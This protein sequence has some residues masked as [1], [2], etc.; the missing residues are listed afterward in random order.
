MNLNLRGQLTIVRNILLY[1]FLSSY[2]AVA[3]G[4]ISALYLTAG[5]QARM[6]RVQGNTVSSLPEV[7]TGEYALA[8]RSTVRTLN[9]SGGGA[10]GNEYTLAGAPL[11]ATYANNFGSQMI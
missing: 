2:S 9:V 7:H 8:V 1:A 4:P 3:A 10:L 6:F 5:D 11:A